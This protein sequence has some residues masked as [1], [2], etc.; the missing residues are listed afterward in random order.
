MDSTHIPSDVKVLDL[1][2]FEDGLL[3][4]HPKKKTVKEIKDVRITNK[5]LRGSIPQNK[6]RIK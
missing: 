4:L 3:I 2:E 1:T 5:L 6:I